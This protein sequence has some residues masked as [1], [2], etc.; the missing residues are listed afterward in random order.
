MKMKSP[1][2]STVSR[3]PE[4][5][6]SRVIASSR[7]SPCSSVTW[8]WSRVRMFGVASIWSTRYCDIFAS[9]EEP[10]TTIVTVPA[11]RESIMAAWPAEL[12]PPTT[13]TSSPW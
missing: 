4:S 12:A 1:L 8:E 2:A 10:R 6:S 5:T 13:Y 9:S 11:K 3:S 7:D